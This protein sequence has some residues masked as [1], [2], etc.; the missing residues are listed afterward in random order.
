MKIDTTWHLID[1]IAA[2]VIVFDDQGVIQDV[3][4][5]CLDFFDFKSPDKL[6]SKNLVSLVDDKQQDRFSSFLQEI[7]TGRSSVETTFRLTDGTMKDVSLVVHPIPQGP[8]LSGY[9]VLTIEEGLSGDEYEQSWTVNQYE[10]IRW[11][12]DQGRNLLSLN[13]WSDILDF[14]SNALQEKLKDCILLALTK[15]D[16]NYLQLEG[17][18][19]IENNLLTQVSKLVGVDFQGRLFPIDDRFRETYSKRSLF[20]HP[21]GLEEFASSQVPPSISKRIKKMVGIDRIGLTLDII[22]V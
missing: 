14:A 1:Q 17:V 16:D 2:P 21:G 3:N 7:N 10:D 13:H 19:G 20:E 11:L 6:I 15:L 9:F 18:Y 22:K 5:A 12:A 4:P 8:E